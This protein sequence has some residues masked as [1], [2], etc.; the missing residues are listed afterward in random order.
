MLSNVLIYLP[1]ENSPGANFQ[2]TTTRGYV[3]RLTVFRYM[4]LRS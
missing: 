2:V 3:D 1:L 4:K